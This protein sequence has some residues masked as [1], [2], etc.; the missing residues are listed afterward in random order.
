MY[1]SVCVCVCNVVCVCVCVCVC[2]RACVCMCVCVCVCKCMDT[3]ACLIISNTPLQVV[4]YIISVSGPDA[5]MLL[6]GTKKDRVT[7]QPKLREVP[8]NQAKRYAATKHMLDAI[9]TSAKDN[10]NIEST[11]MKMARALWRQNEG[12]D[13]VTDTEMSFKLSTQMDGEGKSHICS[14]CSVL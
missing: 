13:S 5:M 3:N 2:V 1:Y 9:E 4:P 14:S 11:F 8:Y 10:T 6:I 7:S 12:L